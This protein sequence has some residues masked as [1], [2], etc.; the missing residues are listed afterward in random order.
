MKFYE[1]IFFYI[2]DSS[3]NIYPEDEKNSSKFTN[4]REY[5]CD[6]F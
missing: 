2:I 4:F 6:K 5:I 1:T 3:L